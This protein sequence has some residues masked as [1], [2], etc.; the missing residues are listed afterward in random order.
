MIDLIIARN[1]DNTIAI[2]GMLPWH[3]PID[4][5]RF[6]QTTLRYDFVVM[7]RQTWEDLPEKAR[8]RMNSMAIVIT[9]EPEKYYNKE[10]VFYCTINAVYDIMLE[11]SCLCIGGAKTIQLLEPYIHRIFLTTVHQHDPEDIDLLKVTKFD[12]KILKNFEPLEGVVYV[13]DHDFSIL[14]RKNG[15]RR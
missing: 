15:K 2:D 8:A 9:R 13:N 3:C 5:K 14:R 10:G 11:H 4:L 12:Y 7:G 6:K 1:L